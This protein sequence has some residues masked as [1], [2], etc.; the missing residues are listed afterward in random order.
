MILTH[1][2]LL[3]AGTAAAALT[4]VGAKLALA[5]TSGQSAGVQAEDRVFICNED[6]NTL[7]VIDPRTNTVETTVNLISAAP[8]TKHLRHAETSPAPC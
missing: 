7:T 2:T 3:Q 6:S 1:R 8:V 4:S 5:Q